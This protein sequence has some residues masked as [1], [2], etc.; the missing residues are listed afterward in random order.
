MRTNKDQHLND[1]Q[2]EVFNLIVGFDESNKIQQRQRATQRSLEARRAIE[3]HFEK[4]E[5]TQQV[6]DPWLDE[7]MAD[8]E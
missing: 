4:K 1:V 8:I 7:L 6:A 5:L 3:Q 2:T